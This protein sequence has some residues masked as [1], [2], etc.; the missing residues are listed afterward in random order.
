MILVLFVFLPALLTS[1]VSL[2][3]E[4]VADHTMLEFA[5][6]HG[7]G[8]KRNHLTIGWCE[9]TLYIKTNNTVLL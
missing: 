1:Q 2:E 5:N 4:P 3:T 8:K 6:T 7:E 9:I